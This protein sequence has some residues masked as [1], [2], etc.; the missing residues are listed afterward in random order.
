MQFGVVTLFPELVSSALEHGVVGRARQQGQLEL[1]L[2]NPRE[3]TADRHRT[4]DDRPFGGG[5]GMVM[6]P[7]PLSAA[8]VSLKETMPDAPV[9]YLS[10]QGRPFDQALAREWQERG[11]LILVA[12]RYEGIDE[13]VIDSLIDREVSL[14]DFVLS[15]G[16]F[17]ALAVIDAVSRLVPGVL[18]DPLSAEEDSFGTD[19]LL[20]CP[21]Y[22]RPEVFDQHPVPAVL[23]SGDHKAIARWRR[24]QALARTRDRRPDL[25][26][27]AEL[28]EDDKVFLTSLGSS[29][30]GTDATSE[31]Q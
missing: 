25:L 30:E 19:G 1:V 31:E 2:A 6:T 3:R 27:K 21:H 28:T 17:A 10:P 13:R 20:D 8:I 26:E 22:T 24:Q 16:E 23:L 29:A 7:A 11:S 4:V 5:P 9:I 15:G 18:G 12:G 14:G